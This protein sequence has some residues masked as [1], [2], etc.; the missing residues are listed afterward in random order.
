MR[1]FEINNNSKPESELDF[2]TRYELEKLTFDTLP[3]NAYKLYSDRLSK[4][5]PA[6]LFTEP[7]GS[8]TPKQRYQY[9]VNALSPEDFQNIIV[10]FKVKTQQL[11]LIMH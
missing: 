9:I 6:S 8:L 2:F 3:T 4:V 1:L 7:K 5:Y 11:E 10:D